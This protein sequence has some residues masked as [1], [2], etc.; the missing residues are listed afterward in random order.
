[1]THPPPP[2]HN[3]PFLVSH[4]IWIWETLLGL[5]NAASDADGAG[6]GR[7]IYK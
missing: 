7:R 5:R 6:G 1:M 3:H 4:G 2:T